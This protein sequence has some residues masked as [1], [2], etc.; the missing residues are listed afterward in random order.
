MTKWKGITIAAIWGVFAVIMI[1]VAIVAKESV[2]A[3][4]TIAIMALFA[5]LAVTHAKEK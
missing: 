5:T 4:S 3:A 2:V 1:T